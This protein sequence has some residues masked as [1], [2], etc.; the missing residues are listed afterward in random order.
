MA[1]DISDVNASALVGDTADA[2]LAAIRLL[3]LQLTCCL[4]A[5]DVATKLGKPPTPAAAAE[6]PTE[7]PMLPRSRHPQAQLS[8]AAGPE[9]AATAAAA[10]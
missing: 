8:D 2:P 5:C 3:H 7:M 9:R 4:S 10:D 1:L 6:M